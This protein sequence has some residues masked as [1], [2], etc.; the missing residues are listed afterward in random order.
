MCK[1][2]PDYLAA[3]C[4]LLAQKGHP[5][6]CLVLLVSD[7]C[8]VWPWTH[9]NQY[10]LVETATTSAGVS[11]PLAD[12]CHSWATLGALVWRELVTETFRPAQQGHPV[13]LL[14]RLLQ[15]ACHMWSGPSE[16]WNQ[17]FLSDLA[18]TLEGV[19]RPFN[20]GCHWAATLGATPARQ[21]DCATFIPEQQGQPLPPLTLL[22]SAACQT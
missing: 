13:P 19:T 7:A 8:H 4:G 18:T 1:V 16:H 2:Y 6:P 11:V 20:V 3:A 15:V 17:Y 9:W 14:T 10:F 12:G 22:C 21:L 5:L